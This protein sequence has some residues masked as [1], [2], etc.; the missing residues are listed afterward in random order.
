[1]PP[2][3]GGYEISAGESQRLKIVFHPEATKELIEAG[4]YYENIS[5]GLGQNF[6]DAI[7]S[8]LEMLRRNPE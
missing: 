6:L 4:R 2:S 5:E 3:P 7:D 1:M 8:S